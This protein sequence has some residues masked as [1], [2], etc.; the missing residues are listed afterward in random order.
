MSIQTIVSLRKLSRV[1]PG[2]EEAVLVT[3]EDR[4]IGEFHPAPRAAQE[5]AGGPSAAGEHRSPGGVT[6]PAQPE[7]P[8]KRAASRASSKPAPAGASNARAM[9][10]AER[11]AV[12]RRVNRGGNERG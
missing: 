3:H 8:A 9:T 11:D 2:L 7:A 1:A 12:L 6:A 5:I 4:I 10:Q